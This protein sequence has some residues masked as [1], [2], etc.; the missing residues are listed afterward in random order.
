MNDPVDELW[1]YHVDT[2]TVIGG[3]NLGWMYPKRKHSDLP[4]M[5]RGS[6]TPDAV[7]LFKDARKVGDAKVV[8][9]CWREILTWPAQNVLTYHDP[10]GHG[11]S[12]D[13]RAALESAAR[14]ARQLLPAL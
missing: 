7:Y 13:G 9:A 5:L 14:E 11:F 1:A 3:E 10:P 12:G 4:A 2:H 8:D 6:I